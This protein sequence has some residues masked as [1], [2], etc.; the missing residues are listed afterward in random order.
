MDSFFLRPTHLE[1][2]QP[3][4][5]TQP[6]QLKSVR[7][8]R[9]GYLV[10]QKKQAIPINS[11]SLSCGV[12]IGCE[13]YTHLNALAASACFKRTV[14]YFFLETLAVKKAAKE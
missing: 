2:P 3:P 8:V 13:T 4:K 14:Y 12:L 5:R 10:L 11:G 7:K 1:E 9:G 6:E